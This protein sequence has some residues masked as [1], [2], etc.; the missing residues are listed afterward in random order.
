MTVEEMATRIS[1]I[2]IKFDSAGKGQEPAVVA[3]ACACYL[4]MISAAV[5]KTDGNHD[6]F[7]SI[8]KSA[9]ADYIN[10]TE[11]K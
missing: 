11:R 8:L 3:A 10:L 5:H 9:R 7:Q 6:F 2:V 4:V 1:E